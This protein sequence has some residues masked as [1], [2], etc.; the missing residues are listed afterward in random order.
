MKLLQIASPAI[1]PVTLDEVKSQLVVLDDTQ[2]DILR[3]RIT[4][5]RE[6]VE[7]WLSRSLITQ[8]WE[9]ASDRFP[10]PIFYRYPVQSIESIKYLDGAAVE[11]TVP[12]T[13][14]DLDLYERPMQAL[15]LKLNQTWPS[16]NTEVNNVKVRFIAG[17]GDHRTMVPG[18]IRE[19]IIMLIEHWTKFQSNNEVGSLLSTVPFAIEQMLHQYRIVDEF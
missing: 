8:T 7:L 13:V 1:E 9:I 2:D 5:V 4:E 12:T 11:Q 10:P 14:Y 17:Y 18:P 19:A 15:R 3:R 6:Y 16:S